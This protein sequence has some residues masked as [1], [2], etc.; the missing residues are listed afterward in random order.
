MYGG[1]CGVCGVVLV[2]VVC[3]SVVLWF[4]DCVCV[5]VFVCVCLCVCGVCV[6]M[7]VCVFVC[8]NGLT[9]EAIP[10]VFQT[11]TLQ[12][13]KITKNFFER[14]TLPKFYIVQELFLFC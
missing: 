1:W 7:C 10:P 14:G 4:C 12:N 5:F 6:C 11:C 3:G 13:H 2:C 9:I 8:V